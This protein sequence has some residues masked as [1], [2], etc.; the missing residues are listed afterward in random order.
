MINVK[1]IEVKI[2]FDETSSFDK[3]PRC[4]NPQISEFRVDGELIQGVTSFIIDA[5][6]SKPSSIIVRLED[7]TVYNTE[8]IANI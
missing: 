4:E 5:S 8:S 3:Y 1:L 7:G 2:K 6:A